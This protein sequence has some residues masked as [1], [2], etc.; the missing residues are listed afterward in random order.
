MSDPTIPPT[1]PAR[2]RRGLRVALVASL[3]VNV[4]VIGVLAGGALRMHRSEPPSPG[5]PDIRA[6]W[7]AMPDDAR[8]SLRQMA[9]E[10]GFPGDHGPRQSREERRAQAAATNARLLAVLRADPFDAEAFAQILQGD[11]EAMERRLDAAHAAFARQLESL[12]SAAR[13]A[14]ADRLEAGWRERQP[15]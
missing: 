13:R 2:P 6:L 12:D 3:M 1:V 9:R 14:M 4:L 11:R 7:R 5:L 15:G 10:Q 8:R